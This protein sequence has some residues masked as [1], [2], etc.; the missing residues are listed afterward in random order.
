[1]SFVIE[2][3][4]T[5]KFPVRLKIRREDGG[6][7]EHK[8]HAVFKRMSESEVKAMIDSPEYGDPF[9]VQQTL[10]GWEGVTA[11]DRTPL[12]FEPA[13]LAAL[14]EVAGARAAIV[15][16]FFQSLDTESAEAAEL[17]N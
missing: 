7:A 3:S 15:R 8:F 16:A 11:P 13:T 2:Q 6:V 12:P 9:V 14:Q 5:Y 4:P 10:K 17:G 1:M